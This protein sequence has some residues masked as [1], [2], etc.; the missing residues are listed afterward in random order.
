M[1]MFNEVG[2]HDRFEAAEAAGFAGVELTTP[3]EY[4][5]DRVAADLGGTNLAL[6]L[7]NMPRGDRAA[8]YRGIACL[9]E[10]AAEFE[11][12]VGVAIEY[13]AAVR[14]RQVSCMAGIAPPGVD[15][16]VLRE[17][18]VSN[19]R[20]AAPRLEQV[21]IRLLI[22][23][24][25]TRAIPGFYLQR[26]DQALSIIEEVGCANLYLQYDVYH[27][28][29]MEG[30]LVPTIRANLDIIGHI[31]I[32]DTPGRNEP[33]TGEINYAFLLGAL[34]EMGYEGWVGCEY[35]PLTATVDGLGWANQYLQAR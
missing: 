13:A 16:A 12:S 3:Y 30:D 20:F 27:M 2:F 24:I 32:A 17:T 4:D 19:L 5:K 6:V 9:P 31:Q 10:K 34:D 1:M 11:E 29:V 18:L 22:E 35:R 7:H 26:T 28:Q 23:P 8:G 15:A 25:S 14:C 21:G 33:G